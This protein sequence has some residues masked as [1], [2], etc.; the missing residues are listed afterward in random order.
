MTPTESFPVDL[1]FP[2][3]VSIGLPVYNG[4]AFVKNAL[5]MLLSQTEADFELI[6]SDNCS[7]D[8]S[9]EI[10]LTAAASDSRIRYFR[11][12][13]RLRAY[14]NF[15]YVLS[16]ARGTYFMWAACDDGW[17]LDFIEKLAQSLDFQPK[18]IMAFGDVNI[19]TPSDKVGYLVPFDFQTMDLGVARRLRKL[20]MLQCFYF[21]GLWRTNQIKS[22]PYSYCAWW[23][24]L[25]LMLA[26]ST[27]GPFLYVPKVR[28]Y[29]YEVPKS[30]LTRVMQQDYVNHFNLLMGIGG[31]IAAVYRA[32]SKTGGIF[33]GGYAAMLVIWKQILA[34]PG[35]ISRRLRL[36]KTRLE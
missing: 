20:A 18:A 13:K 15:Q 8:G 7:S 2:P 35:Y 1:Q 14:D 30:N 9:T 28:F 32:C 16:H 29:Y 22:V 36:I 4:A 5:D 23:P 24:D 25:P 19:V 6:I 17:D 33:I 31:L 26:A 34:I 27:L 3:R 10:L 11:Q 12:E 21:Y